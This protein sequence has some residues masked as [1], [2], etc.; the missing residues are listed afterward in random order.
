MAPTRK[1]DVGAPQVPLSP[2]EINY[3]SY[4]RENSLSR[5][6]RWGAGAPLSESP[7]TEAILID[8]DW[9]TTVEGHINSWYTT[10]GGHINQI[11]IFIFLPMELQSTT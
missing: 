5:F 11:A 6:K 10:V 8:S 7:G 2:A 9:Y 3:I 1:S 4:Y